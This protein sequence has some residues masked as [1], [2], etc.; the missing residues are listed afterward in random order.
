MDLDIL[1]LSDHTTQMTEVLSREDL[2]LRPE[3]V[4]PLGTKKGVR[5]KPTELKIDLKDLFLSESNQKMLNNGLYNI[6]RQNGGKQSRDKLFVFLK[7]LSNKFTADNDLN[8]YE[9][10][11]AQ[12]TGYNNYAEC[13]RA[14]NNDYHKVV[15]RYFSWNTANPFKDRVE[16][17]PHDF[18]V[19]KK[20]YD[21]SHEDHGTL[22]LWREQFTQ[23]LNSQFRDNNRIPVYRQSIHTRHYDRGNEGLQQNDPDRSSLETPVYGYDMSQIYKN[24]DKYSSTE[25]YSM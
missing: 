20:G 7:Q 9:T 5:N 23:V 18:R 17:G 4:Q 13:L 25:W 21:L 19:L 14:I 24:L 12:T 3:Q 16:V 1:Y 10:A 2:M 11:E 15:Y 6:Y 22:E 8:S